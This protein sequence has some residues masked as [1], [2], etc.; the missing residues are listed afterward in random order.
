MITGFYD[1]VYRNGLEKRVWRCGRRLDD[2]DPMKVSRWP[3]GRSLD[4]SRRKTSWVYSPK[5]FVIWLVLWQP[6][7]PAHPTSTSQFLRVKR[8]PSVQTTMLF[9]QNPHLIYQKFYARFDLNTR[10]STQFSASIPDLNLL[11]KHS[12]TKNREIQICK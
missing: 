1:S 2:L 10:H 5:R 3:G 6:S 12:I 9:P 11:T 8:D 4:S 7:L